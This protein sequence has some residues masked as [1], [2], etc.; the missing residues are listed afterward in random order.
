M[1][2]KACVD[3]SCEGPVTIVAFKATSISNPE[4]ITAASKQ[5]DDFIQ[6]KHPKEIVFDFGPVKFFCSQVLGV[7]LEVR[8]KLKEYGGKVVISAIN[9][10]LYRVFK[11]TNL[12]KVFSFFPDK[13]S[14]IR[15]AGTN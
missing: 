12:D 7:L 11:I 9:P 1:N 15:A 2:E 5:I 8:A 4:G 10:Q 14:A 13:D 3:I 6:E